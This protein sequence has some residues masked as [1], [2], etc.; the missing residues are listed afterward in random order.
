MDGEGWFCKGERI[1]K[2]IKLVSMTLQGSSRK[3][4]ASV[5]L[6]MLKPLI[7]WIT[8][9]WKISKEVKILDHLIYLLRNL[10]VGQIVTE[11]D[12]DQWTGSKLGTEYAKAIYCHLAFLTYMQSMSCKMPGWMKHKLE[13]RFP[14]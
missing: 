4:P 10:Y 9:N 5:S 3:T 14:G 12:M 13:S 8:T 1:F 7:V 6:T 11:L 2:A